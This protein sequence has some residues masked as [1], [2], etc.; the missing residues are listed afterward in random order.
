MKQTINRNI[1]LI[2][3]NMIDRIQLSNK[4]VIDRFN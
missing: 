1:Q 3:I 2:A 4:R